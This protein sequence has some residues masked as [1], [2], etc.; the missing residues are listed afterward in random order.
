MDFENKKRKLLPSKFKHKNPVFHNQEET[1]KIDTIINT[2]FKK[3]FTI[4]NNEKYTLPEPESLFDEN[5][6]EI[7]ELQKFKKE[8]NDTKSK[9]NNYNYSEWHEHTSQR[10][11]AKDVEWRLRR[12]F[13]PEFVT[14]AWCKFHEIVSK[15]PLI[16]KET[17]FA[18]HNKFFSLHLCEAPGA[19]ITCLNHWL[20][21]NTPT[22]MWDWLAMTYNPYYEGHTNSNMISDDR[23]IRYT[24]K[25]WF[26]G[27]DFTGDLMNLDNLDSLIEKCKEKGKVNLITA[28]GSIN[29]KNDPGE[30]EKIVA[31][32]HFCEVVAAVQI[33]ETGGNL[34]L[35]IFTI[36]EHETVSLIYMLTCI[37]KKI[38]FYK[39]VT[40]REG[41][42]EVYV[43]CLDF[44][45]PEFVLPYISVLRNKYGHNLSKAMF[46]KNDIPQSFLKQIISCAEFFK[47]CQ[48]E[49]IE[50]NILTYNS[51]Q[52]NMSYFE[53]KKIA[54][55]VADKFMSVFPLRKLHIDLQIV[56]NS[57]L[58]KNKKNN[59]ITTVPKESF[60]EIK[61]KQV[62]EP[63]YHLLMYKSQFQFVEPVTK[64][65]LFKVKL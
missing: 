44:K 54:K 26:F 17:I 40:S 38:H 9:L 60:N 39:P 11:K 2:F 28:D 33:L 24:L 1:N 3:S 29:C 23:F 20:K 16:P 21:T 31:N 58:K 35:K 30:Q 14:Q 7:D 65:F 45:G 41:N 52:L 4:S 51:K 6:W 55:L 36:F 22:I 62:L 8:L 64:Q 53:E 42:S 48:C 50:N 19:F 49:V 56:G 34:L 43:I 37:F 5:P 61:K 18:N 25:K 57:Q 10:N 59:W 13:D 27:K 63:V 46:K 12:D 15:Y 32:L 47:N